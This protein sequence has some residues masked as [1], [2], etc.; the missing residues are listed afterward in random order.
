MSI[1]LELDELSQPASCCST[2]DLSYKERHWHSDCF[3]CLT[4]R[5]SIADKP[6]STKDEQ[7]L[8]TECYANEYSSKCHEC[9]KT[10]M[11]GEEQKHLCF[12]PSESNVT[13]TVCVRSNVFMLRFCLGISLC[14][15]IKQGRGKWSTRATPGTRH[16]SPVSA[17]SSP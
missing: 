16:A 13:Y 9:K 8:C 2:Q 14:V 10:I 7:L 17:A 12:Y 4:C 11:P 1:H 15:L 6:F 5:R 3:H